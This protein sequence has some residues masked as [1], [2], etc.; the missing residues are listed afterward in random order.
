[1]VSRLRFLL[2]PL[3]PQSRRPRVKH[4]ST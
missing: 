1:M 2:Q 4:G 3:R